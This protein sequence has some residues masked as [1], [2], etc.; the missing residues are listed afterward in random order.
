MK[1]RSAESASFIIAGV[2]A[3]LTFGGALTDYLFAGGPWEW[4]Y[5]SYAAG[6]FV[7]VYFIA[8][9]IARKFIIYKI[10]PI[11]QIALSRDVKT[12]ELEKKFIDS[13]E[14]L[15]GI[16]REVS[17]VVKLSSEEIA[18][19]KANEIYRREYIGNISHELKT[20]IFNIQGYI[21]TLLDGGLE[22]PSIN[23]LY[24]TRADKSIDRLIN[25]VQDLEQISKLESSAVRLSKEVFDVVE[26][27]RQLIDTIQYEANARNIRI[28]LEAPPQRQ[29][30][31]VFA[32][33]LLIEKVIINLLSNSIHYGKHGGTTRVSFIDLLD[34][35]L[36]EVADTGIGMAE[37]DVIHVFERF[38]RVDKSRSREQG[39]TG[40]GLSIVKHTLAA[41]NEMIS[42]R[43]IPGKGSTFSFTL[44]K[45]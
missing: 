13:D 36:C 4:Y 12:R 41:H 35:V 2:S 39:G 43:S 40:L 8:R 31:M 5:V 45:A 27:T 3:V 9:W 29:P 10:K 26:L 33:K 23:R 14:G 38:Y 25:I 21:N 1:I 44:T 16:E 22:D 24:L 34:K 19:L 11:Y 20:P 42:V 30:I 18:R 15:A 17:D 32:D 28:I 7:A 6:V 37:E